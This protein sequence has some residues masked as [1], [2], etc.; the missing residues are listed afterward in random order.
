[1][2]GIVI[3]DTFQWSQDNTFQ[4][5]IISSDEQLVTAAHTL[6]QAIKHDK[7]FQSPSTAYQE[8]I[9]SLV[10]LFRKKVNEISTKK[11]QP[12]K[13][14]LH[15]TSKDKHIK[16]SSQ[17]QHDSTRLRVNIT[18]SKDN[19]HLRVIDRINKHKP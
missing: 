16:P 10:K 12:I 1:M 6:A 2:S 8:A 3:A 11:L 18:N 9:S 4:L 7:R 15:P 5:P 19:S 14:K 13:E 17:L